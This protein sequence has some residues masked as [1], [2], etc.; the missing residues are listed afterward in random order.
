METIDQI[1][2]LSVIPRPTVVDAGSAWANLSRSVT[3]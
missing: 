2:R 1:L 3:D